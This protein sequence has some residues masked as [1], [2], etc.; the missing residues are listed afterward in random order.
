MEN[1]YLDFYKTGLFTEITARHSKAVEWNVSKFRRPPFFQPRPLCRA[2]TKKEFGWS[3][4]LRSGFFSTPFRLMRFYG[5]SPDI[6]HACTKDLPPP[7]ARLTTSV[8]A[9]RQLRQTASDAGHFPFLRKD[10]P[11]KIC[12]CHRF[13]TRRLLAAPL[14]RIGA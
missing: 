5:Q 9:D 7:A 10:Q 2:V 8:T 4:R 14:L 11:R 3:T 13:T 12:L 6:A 1:G